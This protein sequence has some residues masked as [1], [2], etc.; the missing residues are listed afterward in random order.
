MNNI[1]MCILK[2]NVSATTCFNF[3]LAEDLQL[4]KLKIPLKKIIVC[5]FAT[6]AQAERHVAKLVIAL[7]ATLLFVCSA[8]IVLQY[9]WSI[10][11]R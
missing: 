1:N 5:H 4:Y 11:T 2:L 3:Q 9:L 8:F 7:N 6:S 10:I